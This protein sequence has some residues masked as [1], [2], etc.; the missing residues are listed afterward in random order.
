MRWV[1]RNE[2]KPHRCPLCHAVATWDKST[3][4]RPIGPRTKLKCPRGC[5]VQWRAGFRQKRLG[6]DLWSF[7]KVWTEGL[8][9]AG[10]DG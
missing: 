1:Q 6:M 8:T 2:D 7:W 4:N 9:S 10:Y 5:G 3:Q